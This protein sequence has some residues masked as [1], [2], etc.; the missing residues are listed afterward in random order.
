ME[1]YGT[2]IP[3]Q[4]INADKQILENTDY[5]MLKAFEHVLQADSVDELLLRIRYARDKYKEV[6]ELR[7]QCRDD[8]EANLVLG[9]QNEELF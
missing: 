1:N 4:K 2:P 8:I 3:E 6:L 5:K 7:Q 9:N